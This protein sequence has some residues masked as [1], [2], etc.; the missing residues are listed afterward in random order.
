MVG[1]RTVTLPA[2]AKVNL[3][4]DVRERLPDGYHLVQTVMQQI[5]LADEVSVRLGEEEGISLEC[6]EPTIPADSP[7]LAWRAAEAFYMRLGEVP[8]VCI[9][10]LKR[11]P[12]QAGL[13]GG[14]SN[15]AAV[16]RALNILYGKPFSVRQLQ[17]LARTLGSD[18]AFFL[19][20]G[21][22]LVEGIGDQVTPLPTPAVYPIVVAVP[23]VSIS[24]AWAYGRIDEERATMGLEAL[25]P[26]RTPAMVHALQHGQSWL[27]LL[28]NDFEAVVMPD[29]VEIQAVKLHMMSHGALAAVLC[30]SGSGVMGVYAEE[31]EAHRALLQ[32]RRRGNRAWLCT[33][34][35]Q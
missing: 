25:P 23:P 14:S 24:T 5:S 13:G 12:A 10:L 8:R 27:P 3:T 1:Y 34:S 15:A 18:V 17:P 30:G 28:H 2:F 22:A 35:W 21:T 11:I 6:S 31:H 7:N 26:P 20:G 32:L 33:F 29:F 9:S 16:L 4:L 19:H